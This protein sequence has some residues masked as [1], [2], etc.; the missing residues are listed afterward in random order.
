[1]EKA[2][3][4]YLKRTSNLKNNSNRNP[5]RS[6]V[7][8]KSTLYYVVNF[9]WNERKNYMPL[10]KYLNLLHNDYTLNNNFDKIPDAQLVT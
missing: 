10:K 6:V 5:V 3:R 2:C 7:T 8:I 9:G 1:M 4:K